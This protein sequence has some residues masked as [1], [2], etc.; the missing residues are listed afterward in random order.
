MREKLETLQLPQLK[1]MAK[2]Q[3]IK[4]AATM[5]KAELINELCKIAERDEILKTAVAPPQPRTPAPATTAT[6]AAVRVSLAD[7]VYARRRPPV[8]SKIPPK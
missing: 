3:G 4:G 7:L 6:P 5:R 2:A 1:E 8:P